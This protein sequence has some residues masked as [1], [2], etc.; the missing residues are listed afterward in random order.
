MNMITE[1]K[2]RL[3]RKVSEGLPVGILLFGWRLLTLLGGPISRK[4]LEERDRIPVALTDGSGGLRTGAELCRAVQKGQ[5]YIENQ[6]E[7]SD[8]PFGTH[9]KSNLASSGCEIIAAY[10]YCLYKGRTCSLA[11]LIRYFELH[12][13][14]LRGAFG[15]EPRSLYRFLRRHFPKLRYCYG[16]KAENAVYAGTP[17]A[18]VVTVQNDRENLFAMIHTVC[19]TKE[20]QGYVIHNGGRK[21]REGAWSPSEGYRTFRDAVAHITESPRL[22]AVIL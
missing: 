6:P 15:L 17:E 11:G 2:H 10:N 4:A 16:R 9:P 3:I 7:L 13:A 19:I 8:I 12:G 20:E 5:T 22:L 14:S 21:N 18:A 1:I